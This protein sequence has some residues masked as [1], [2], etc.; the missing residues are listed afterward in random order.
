MYTLAFHLWSDPVKG[1]I[2]CCKAVEHTVDTKYIIYRHMTMF[3]HRI[4]RTV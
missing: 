2:S 4:K 1:S 3:I